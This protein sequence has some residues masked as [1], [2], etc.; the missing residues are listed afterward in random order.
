MQ[1]F[2]RFVKFRN[3]LGGNRALDLY[4][5]WIKRKTDFV[6][7]RKNIH[8][9]HDFAKVVNGKIKNCANIIIP[10]VY[11]DLC[12]DRVIVME[13]INISTINRTEL[14]AQN[15]LLVQSAMN[16][17]I[18]MSFWAL[19]HSQKVVFHGDPHAGNICVDKNGNIYFLDM[20]L[21]C[22]LSNT[23]ADYCRKFFLAAYAGNYQ[24]M[25]NLLLD[26][27]KFDQLDAKAFLQDIREYCEQVKDK[28]LTFYFVDMIEICLHHNFLPPDFLFSMAKA[29]I[30]LYG[31]NHFI[32]N[33]FDA[34]KLLHEQVAGYL[35]RRSAQDCLRL[36][37]S[38][39][40]NFPLAIENMISGQKFDSGNSTL[41]AA[42][43]ALQHLE[44]T[45][46]L[47]CLRRQ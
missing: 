14:T 27:G 29:F 33:D 40:G 4:L 26:C 39:V 31:I 42:R 5:G 7:E 45:V 24:R 20:G 16:D 8:E 17:Y 11:D 6:N 38:A 10:K 44:E 19:L 36:A 35:L 2:G 37:T 13:Y 21:T 46:D 22:I 47:V 15:K 9:Y 23:D 18:R 43:T 34:R 3:L 25:F 12:T 32:N 41:K 1:R 28:E 30:C